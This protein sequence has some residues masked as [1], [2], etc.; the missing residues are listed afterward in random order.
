MN[1]IVFIIMWTT[2]IIIIGRAQENN[3]WSNIDIKYYTCI[4]TNHKM[5]RTILGVSHVKL[6]NAKMVLN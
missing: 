3:H 6:D 1:L 2:V 4:C 5:Q